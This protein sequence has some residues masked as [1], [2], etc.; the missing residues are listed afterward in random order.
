MLFSPPF[1]EPPKAL[2]TVNPPA[3][4]ARSVSPV[5]NRSGPVPVAPTQVIG[6]SKPGM[7]KA[8]MS[9]RYN[10]PIGLYSDTEVMSQFQGQSKFLITPDE[11]G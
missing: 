3:L 5:E 8:I 11:E 7:V 9:Q 6:P 1:A 10:T 4:Q 2:K